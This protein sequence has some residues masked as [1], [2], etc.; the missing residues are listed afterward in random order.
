MTPIIFIIAAL[1]LGLGAGAIYEVLEAP[2]MPDSW[3]DDTRTY[4]R[5]PD[6]L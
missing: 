5:C 6:C 3:H 1:L 2:V 4:V